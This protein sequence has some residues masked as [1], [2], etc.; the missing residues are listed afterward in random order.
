MSDEDVQFASHAELLRARS[1]LL[2][3][4]P[5][6]VREHLKS[7]DFLLGWPPADWGIERHEEAVK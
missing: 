7:I 2:D 1:R 4:L 6:K 5:W 3:E